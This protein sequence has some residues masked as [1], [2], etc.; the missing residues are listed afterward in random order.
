M[1]RT[2]VLTIRFNSIEEQMIRDAARLEGKCLSDF[3]REA[4][5]A[6]AERILKGVERVAVLHFTG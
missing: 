1:K 4:V 3:V 6:E 2:E 5:L